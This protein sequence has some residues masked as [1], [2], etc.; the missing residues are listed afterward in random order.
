MRQVVFYRASNGNTKLGEVEPWAD[1]DARQL[2]D[3]DRTLQ[4]RKV[5]EKL[6][7][8]PICAKS[9]SSFIDFIPAFPCT[10]RFPRPL[11]LGTIMVVF[12]SMLSIFR[13]C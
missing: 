3:G 12:Q 2:A 1:T 8:D 5:G 9:D 10:A 6:H 4:L 13:L 11:L 7:T